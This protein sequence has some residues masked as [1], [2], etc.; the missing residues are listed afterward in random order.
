[1]YLRKDLLTQKGWT[2][3]SIL[4]TRAAKNLRSF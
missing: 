2:T 3:P 1:M 4:I